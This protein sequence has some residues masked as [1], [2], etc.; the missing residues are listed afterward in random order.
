MSIENLT[1]RVVRIYQAARPDGVDDLDTGLLRTLD[2]EP[3]AAALD[4]MPLVTTTLDDT[5]VELV[6]YGHISNLP[7]AR[8]GVFLIVPLEVALVLRPRRSDLPVTSDEVA[9]PAGTVIGCRALAQP[10]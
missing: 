10:I 6:E 9:T 4:P 2:P 5:S 8:D 7:P 3:Q 1:P